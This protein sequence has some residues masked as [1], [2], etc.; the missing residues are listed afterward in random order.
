MKVFG[1]RLAETP[2]FFLANMLALPI[3]LIFS[4]RSGS[5]VFLPQIDGRADILSANLRIEWFSISI[6]QNSFMFFTKSL[7][8]FRECLDCL[9]FSFHKNCCRSDF[10]CGSFIGID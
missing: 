3:R 2:L 9:F 5:D 10:R 6:A 1:F 7:F 8:F 4:P